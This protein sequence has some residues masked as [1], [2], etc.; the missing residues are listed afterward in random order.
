MTV[1]AFAA[2][3]LEEGLQFVSAGTYRNKAGTAGYKA[4]YRNARSYFWYSV[5]ATDATFS[6]AK[7]AQAITAPRKKIQ[8]EFPYVNGT[9]NLGF[10]ATVRSG[11]H[12]FML[13]AGPEPP[14]R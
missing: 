7:V 11:D 10:E 14:S 3:L 5:S 12:S 13:G 4:I 8:R 1:N 9:G 2:A 6:P